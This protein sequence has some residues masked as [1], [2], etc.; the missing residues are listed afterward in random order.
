[1]GERVRRIVAAVVLLIVGLL[2]SGRTAVTPAASLERPRIV[3]SLEEAAGESRGPFVL[4]FFSLD[5]PVCWEELFE[6]RYLLVKNTIPIDLIGISAETPEDLEPFLEKH[7]FFSPVVSD[8]RRE[9]FR[10]FRV[11]LEPFVVVLEGDRVLY[12]DDDIDDLVT[13]REKLRQCVLAINSRRPS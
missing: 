4:V 2:G 10:R 12:R 5:C 7:G 9:L 8:R 1:M 13:R 11:R 3:S 6:A